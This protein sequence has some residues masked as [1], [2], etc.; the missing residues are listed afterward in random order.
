[1]SI[2]KP[3]GNDPKLTPAGNNKTNAAKKKD[4]ES[5]SKERLNVSRHGNKKG[6]QTIT[7]SSKWF[8]K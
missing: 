8:R 2:D 4:N 1:V 3:V 7:G 5:T 6:K